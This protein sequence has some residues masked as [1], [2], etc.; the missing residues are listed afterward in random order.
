[1]TADVIA[2]WRAQ[3]GALLCFVAV[4][5]ACAGGE[6]SA[7]APAAEAD[8]AAASAS[9]PAD[10]AAASVSPPSP[11]AAADTAPV[12]A[13]AAPACAIEACVAAF[14]AALV[15]GDVVALTRAFTPAGLRQASAL[16]DVSGAEGTGGIV[17]A[18][19]EALEETDGGRYTALIVLERDDGTARL[20]T[21]WV[22]APGDS[23]RVDALA[24][25]P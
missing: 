21:T 14:A 10:T 3:V 20:R 17:A 22:P 2:R 13:V 19:A 23:W 6:V 11:P 15:S 1:M 7:P 24:V 5:G 18:R 9:A 8:G 25:E 4:V 16:R 12:S